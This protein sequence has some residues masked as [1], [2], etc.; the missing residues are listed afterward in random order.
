MVLEKY[1]GFDFTISGNEICG[2]LKATREYSGI[3]ISKIAG[4][5]QERQICCLK[6][7]RMNSK[8]SSLMFR[9]I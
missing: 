3:D 7:T 1:T 9:R 6:S 8:T 2:F 5:I 4:Q